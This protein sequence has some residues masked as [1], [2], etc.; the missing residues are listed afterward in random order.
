MSVG[1]EFFPGP[2]FSLPCKVL[3][4][5]DKS[6]CRGR[7]SSSTHNKIHHKVVQKMLY[8]IVSNSHEK[9]LS[10]QFTEVFPI[11]STFSTDCRGRNFCS[12]HVSVERKI[13]RKMLYNIV[14]VEC[15]WKIFV[16]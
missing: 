16:F 13:L 11:S 4:V 1:G 10:C 14:K 9:L 6:D 15:R 2:Y 12:T 3:F 8:N 7:N 5:P